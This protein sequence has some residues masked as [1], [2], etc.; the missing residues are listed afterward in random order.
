MIVGSV[1][2]SHTP[3][4]GKASAGAAVE[5][6]FAQAIASVSRTIAEWK[7]NL[8][9]VFFPDHFNGF[10]YDMMP[11]FAVG[12]RA[13][14][15]GDFGTI[16]GPVSVPEDVA[17]DCARCCIRSGIDIATSYRM[18]VDHGAVQPVELL[19]EV[20]PLGDMLP[21]FINCAAPPLPTF[22]RVRALGEAVGKWAADVNRRVLFVA[23]GG[24]SHDPPLPSIAT[25]APDAQAALIDNRNSAHAARLA[26]QSRVYAAA[27]AFTAGEGSLRPLN[28]SW[29]QAFLKAMAGGDLSIADNWSDDV[30][31]EQGGR[32]GHEVRT[33][34]AALAALRHSKDDYTAN[35]AFY[36][37]IKEWLT[38]TAVLA[39][40]TGTA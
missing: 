20:S 15:I 18:S 9:V 32:G 17:A 16:P 37:P 10:F 5:A 29:D 35:V 36:H 38:G 11:S 22:G 30:V 33:W 3:L 12:I 14:S 25:T 34:I 6:E 40:S 2:L 4:L 24:L 1:C 8:T 13:T 31:T 28:P 7:P 27:R 23:S 19:S 39:A 21:I 26:R